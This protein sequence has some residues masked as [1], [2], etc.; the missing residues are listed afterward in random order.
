MNRNTTPSLMSAIRN[1]E[2]QKPAIE[3]IPKEQRR[4]YADINDVDEPIDNIDNL[5]T[6]KNHIDNSNKNHTAKSIDKIEIENIHDY[7][8]RDSR[9]ENRSRAKTKALK[10]DWD[11]GE[12][13][14]EVHKNGYNYGKEQQIGGMGDEFGE[15]LNDRD[16]QKLNGESVWIKEYAKLMKNDFN[17]IRENHN[18]K[19]KHPNT[20]ITFEIAR[21]WTDLQ[22]YSKLASVLNKVYK[23]QQ[24]TPV[25]M[26]GIPLSLKFKDLL[27][28][29]PTGSGK[30][31]AYLIPLIN[32]IITLPPI[33]PEKA[34]DGPYA[35]V[36][37][38][39]RELVIQ[40]KDVFDKLA[41]PLGIRS[42]LVI[43][44]H[45]AEDQV[46]NF[47]SGCE[48]LF[49]TIGRC[50]DLLSN[51]II[52]LNQCCYI[53]IDE[54]DKMIELD[55]SATFEY[56]LDAAAAEYIKSKSEHLVAKEEEAIERGDAIYRVTQMYSATMPKTL[57]DIA[58]KY[59]H[60]P[61]TIIIE[62]EDKLKQNVNHLFEFINDYTDL[63][64]KKVDA[65]QTWLQK[66][67]LP[68]I[69][70]SNTKD[71]VEG[72]SK[73]LRGLKLR[74]GA[75][76]GGYDQ[77]TRESVIEDFKNGKIDL[78]LS[79]DLG[80]R[81]LDIQNLPCVI[82]FD[83]PKTFEGYV[84]R[85]GRTGR[86]GARGTVFTILSRKNADIID[87]LVGFLEEREL[88]V[89]GFL[90]QYASKSNKVIKKDKKTIFTA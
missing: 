74:I 82:N 6:K 16:T 60:S 2:G 48:V 76:H 65:L 61:V 67:P 52:T 19:I 70:F 44:G 21:K 38:P 7:Y 26:Q 8:I 15:E 33:I 25:Q 83:A 31:L 58:N 17:L 55:L 11:V 77:K 46:S 28:I 39:S 49:A 27:C 14:L 47:F 87:D 40:I 57:L 24:P 30:T 22:F 36:M 35:L 23:F 51:H 71:R 5:L 20:S 37:A 43:G 10:F 41:M 72:L 1:K 86:A 73:E 66:L 84:H 4:Q 32:F 75:Y 80:G 59:L 3:Y 54:A 69:L 18:I 13:T 68:A 88:K 50:Q 90:Y 81:G 42:L 53:V 9:N 89:P 12:D 63:Y 62:T 78:L 85:S 64:G 29:A 79:T 56:I 34:F 45:S